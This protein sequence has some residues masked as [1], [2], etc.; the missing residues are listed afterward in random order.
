MREGG[1]G[2]H[3]MESGLRR[4]GRS[5]WWLWFFASVVTILSTLVFLLSSFPSLFL[6]SDHFYELR[7]DQPGP[8]IMG[9]LLL[10]NAWLVYRQWLFR[11]LR[12]QATEQGMD[13]EGSADESYDLSALDPVTGLYTRAS[14][15]HQ[16]GKEIARARRQNTP[17]SFVA[18]HLDDFAQLN[19]RYGRAAADLA[20]KEFARRLK[21]ASR[22]SDFVVRLGGDDF[23]LVLPE[24]SSGS[25]KLILDRLGSLEIDCSGESIPLTYS[26]GWIEYQSGESP[27][28]LFKR[29]ELV[30]QLYKKAARDS[31]SATPSAG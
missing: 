26:A 28:D 20:L 30:L 21:K 4:L 6:H 5:E 22:G 13:A 11:R 24:C 3:Q 16:L 29:A 2:V 8:A 9:L 31:F 18:L 25:A 1:Y 27:A 19:Q 17:L 14:I 15:D 12:R 10:F 23:L 7:S